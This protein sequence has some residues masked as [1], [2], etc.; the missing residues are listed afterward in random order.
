MTTIGVT[1]AEALERLAAEPAERSVRLFAHGTLEVK[2]YA[3]RG[4]DPQ[5]P[6]A[7]DE[8]YVVAEGTGEFVSADARRPFGPGDFLFAPA[9]VVHR[10]ENFTDDFAVW[11][12]FYGPAGGEVPSAQPPAA[13]S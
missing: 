10:F 3:P 11:V 7:R 12:F 2:L 6:H 8:I 1:F 5:G 4:Y 13:G 9:G